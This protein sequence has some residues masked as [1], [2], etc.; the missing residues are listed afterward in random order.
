MI[1]VP[2]V[3]LGRA[4]LPRGEGCV[5][6]GPY[7]LSAL[8]CAIVVVALVA[9]GGGSTLAATATPTPVPPDPA[10]LLRLSG[11]ATS[12]LDSF[13]FRLDHRGGGT[14]IAPNLT[15]TEAD[16]DVVSPD[17][18]AID[19]AGT[20]GAFA[21]RSSLITLGDD[22]YMTNPLTGL[23]EAVP[24]NVSPLGFF[25]PRVGIGSMLTRVQDAVLLATGEDEHRVG[26]VL[27]VDALR[28]LLGPQTAGATVKVELTIDAVTSYLTKAVL[29]GR[30]TASEPDGVVRYITLTRFNEPLIIEAPN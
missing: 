10:E 15:I 6:L 17:K 16:G 21:V 24:R 20:L 5:H 23:W 25:D 28:P 8:L 11:R 7:R 2:L 9:C 19:F 14:P 1:I 22:S 4:S 13:H 29:D 3:V 26:G 30:A 27:P 18:I 12:D